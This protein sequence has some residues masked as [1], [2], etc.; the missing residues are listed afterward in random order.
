M[1]DPRALA[2]RALP[3]AIP[4]AIVV[5]LFAIR[6]CASDGQLDR[7]ARVTGGIVG[8]PPGSEI[9][10]GSIYVARGGPVMFGFQSDGP[11]R[12]T[13]G[14]QDLRG[15]DVVKNRVVIG[16]G[17]VAIRV[18]AHPAAHVR[19]LW[20]PVGRRGDLEYVPTSSL[21]PAPPEQATFGAWV[22]AAPVDGVIA[23]GL[24]LTVVGTLLWCARARLRAIPRDVWLAIGGVFALALVA[25]LW[26]LGGQGQTFDEDVNWVA[27]RN[28][29]TNLVG[30]DGAPRSWIWNYEHPPVM[31]YLVGIG[32]QFADG[33]GPA[34]AMSALVSAL[35]CALLVPIGARLYRP[36]AGL[37]AGAIA[38]LLPQL[39][40]HGQIVGHESPTLLWW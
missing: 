5:A 18:A 9:H 29:I 8:D 13:V 37:F 4:I 25:R 33:F 22:G 27:G 24:L 32:A 31:K 36:R 35:G 23:L 38:A 15:R 26:N 11:T 1:L 28:Y 7:L 6:A 10:T 34:R 3:I 2:R 39:V 19:L 40:A 30:L 17:P 20:S 14:G 12:L 16:A 21:S